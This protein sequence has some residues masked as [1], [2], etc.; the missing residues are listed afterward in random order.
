VAWAVHLLPPTP[1]GQVGD[2]RYFVQGSRL[3]VGHGVAGPAG[4]LHVFANYPYLQVGPLSLVAARL[5]LLTATGTGYTSAVV[6]IMVLG[7]LTIRLVERAGHHLVLG[8]SRPAASDHYLPLVAMVGGV[9]LLEEWSQL[10]ATGHLDD[11]LA[12][13]SG[14]AAVYGI[15]RRW[16]SLAGIAV[17][18]AAASKPWGVF[19]LPSLLIFRGRSA[20]LSLG[21]A[22]AV[23]AAAWL[24]FI[25]ADPRTL[26]AGKYTILNSSGSTLHLLGVDTQTTPEWVRPAQLIACLLAGTLVVGRRRWPAFLLAAVAARL[27]LDGGTFTYYDAG[28]VLGALLVDMLV[29]ELP[30]PLATTLL[31]C[32]LRLLPYLAPTAPEARSARTGILAVC[33]LLPLV[34]GGRLRRRATPGVRREEGLSTARGT[35]APG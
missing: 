6:V 2:W 9:I 1:H 10:A 19:M 12:L 13:T 27:L 31:F 18:L 11:A 7:L 16:P 23:G 33:L 15:A 5:T 14:A 35:A 17:G 3:L 4:G 34:P 20:A 21:L 26:A 22:T 8:Q 24:P 25:V 28:L 30:V 32:A 29:L